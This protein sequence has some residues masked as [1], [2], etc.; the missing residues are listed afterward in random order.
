MKRTDWR[1]TNCSCGK[2]NK[3][4]LTVTM[5]DC[6]DLACRDRNLANCGWKRLNTR[7]K[8]APFKAKGAA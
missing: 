8:W 6:G 4:K 2:P 3:V 5:F 1:K 7:K